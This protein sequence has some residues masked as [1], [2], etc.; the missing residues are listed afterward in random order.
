MGLGGK[1]GSRA[2]EDITDELCPHSAP[3]GQCHTQVMDD[4]DFSAAMWTLSHI[5]RTPTL[6][7]ALR[8]EASKAISS[9]T[10]PKLSTL[11]RL[12]AAQ[13]PPLVPLLSSCIQETLRLCTSSFSIRRVAEDAIL[14]PNICGNGIGKHAGLS[15]KK[16][17][18]LICQTRQ[19]H[20]D[21]DGWGHNASTWRAERFLDK[22]GVKA[23]K[24]QMSP[25]GGGVSMVRHD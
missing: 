5:L 25:F 6:I 13:L 14:P 18:I 20:L 17:E 23:V 4:S 1:V 24:G 10:P 19:S 11:L 8:S 16:D 21:T 9:M 15:L 7:E 2:R 12:P 22:D 3:Y